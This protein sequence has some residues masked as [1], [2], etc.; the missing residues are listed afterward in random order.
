MKRAAL[1][2]LETIRGLMAPASRRLAE[3]RAATTLAR[4]GRKK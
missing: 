4:L 1:P 2:D 3:E